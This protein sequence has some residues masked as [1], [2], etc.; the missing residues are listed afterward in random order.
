MTL[1]RFLSVTTY[2]YYLEQFIDSLVPTQRKSAISLIAD[3]RDPKTIND[4]D[5]INIQEI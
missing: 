2:R 3:F 4:V 5:F 1:L